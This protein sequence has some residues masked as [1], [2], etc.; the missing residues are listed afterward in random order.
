[1]PEPVP[2]PAPVPE[3]EPVVAPEP[4]PEPE[5]VAETPPPEPKPVPA[6]K[7]TPPKRKKVVEEPK[8]EPAASDFTSVLKNVEKLKQTASAEPTP[9]E[10]ETQTPPQP[11]PAVNPA[12]QL[13][14]SDIDVIRQQVAGCW[15]VDP[16]MRGIEEMAVEVHVQLNPDGSVFTADFDRAMAATDPNW[17]IFAESAVRAVKKCSPLPMPTTRPYSAWQYLTL[18]FNPREMLGL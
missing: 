1:V 16:G 4:V 18:V 3:P 12:D 6:Q 11:Q 10:P 17:W 2:E 9:P 5:Q 13:S 7:P 14:A 8:P 15:I